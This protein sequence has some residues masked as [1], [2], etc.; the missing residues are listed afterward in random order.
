VLSIKAAEERSAPN[1]ASRKITGIMQPNPGIVRR[2]HGGGTA[3]LGDGVRV[4]R[5]FAWLEA[6]SVKIALSRPTHQYP[7]ESMRGITQAV[8]QQNRFSEQNKG[9]VHDEH[10]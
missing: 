2:G 10:N 1:T 7:A 9:K 5:Q 8:G 3:V 4:F 6:D